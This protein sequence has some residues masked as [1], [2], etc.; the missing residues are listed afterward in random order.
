[1][2]VLF[3]SGTVA[4]MTDGQLLERFA[5]RRDA[6]GEIAF[7]ALVARHG[8]MVLGV[9]RQ[10]LG[11]PHDAEDAFQATF[12][13][14]ARKAGSLRW[15]D[16]L[17]PWLYGVAQ[18]KTRKVKQQKA[19]RR[20]HEGRRVSRAGAADDRRA[21]RPELRPEHR[22]EAQALH[23][24]LGR[25]PEK[26][27]APIVLCYLEGHTHEAA[28]QALGWPLGTVRGR[29]ARAREQLRA[30]LARRG[31]LPAGILSGALLRPGTA[32]AAVP[33][34]LAE[35]TGRAALRTATGR[36]AAVAALADLGRLWPWALRPA[37]LK[38]AALLALAAGVAA[39]APGHRAPV[40]VPEAVG[41]APGPAPA[42]VPADPRGGG[43][44]RDEGAPDRLPRW[45]SDA[46]RGLRPGAAIVRADRARN[47]GYL[48]RVEGGDGP[49]IFEVHRTGQG[50]VAVPLPIVGRSRFGRD[51]PQDEVPPD[52]L[53]DW[54]GEA[55]A[56][57]GWGGTI[58]RAQVVTDTVFVVQIREEGVADAL[59]VTGR[60]GDGRNQILVRP[61]R[62]VGDH[63]PPSP[64]ATRQTDPEWL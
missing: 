1:M 40:V 10:L 9:C 11:D 59:L 6:D 3:R 2:H 7:A 51:R 54:A 31:L 15:P 58:A 20:K 23:E 36:A 21:A 8:P 56:G 39:V 13:A 30:R 60:S 35:A 55:L 57:A 24:E 28:A 45:V 4:G 19:R 25:L 27:R 43:D 62:P 63:R 64:T 32:R 22:E 26:Y 44:R 50:T 52:R 12:L 37:S 18:R 48:L 34:A 16:R 42:V 17:G 53:P 38:S 33:A 49:R 41:V 5:A 46:V 61:F 29:L 14:L 47:P